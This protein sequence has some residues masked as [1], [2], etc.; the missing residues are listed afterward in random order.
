MTAEAVLY[1]L[2][3]GAGPVTAIVDTRIYPVTMPEGKPLPALVLEHVSTY[4]PPVIDAY[5]GTHMAQT[6]MQC[7]CLAVDHTTSRT[8]ADAVRA[9]A[10]FARGSIA[11]VLV[12][13]VLH[14]GEG[15]AT[16]D[17]ETGTFHQPIDFIVTYQQS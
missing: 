5:A 17:A 14:A 3:T 13:S 16:F 6:R 12:H 4:R 9:A 2:M 1:A 8:L 7:N 10:Q 15:P 11:G